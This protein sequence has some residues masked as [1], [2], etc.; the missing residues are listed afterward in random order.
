M[1]LAA[2][3]RYP[4]RD[5][6]AR[7][8]AVPLEPEVVV[9]S[10]SGVPLDDET[11]CR[12]RLRAFPER[13]RGPGRVSLASIGVEAHLWIVATSATLSSHDSRRSDTFPAKAGF[14]FGG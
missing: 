10:T 8:S 13:L 12:A 4:L 14:S 3:E 7:E 2:A 11:Q 1:A 6:P 9:E 5:G